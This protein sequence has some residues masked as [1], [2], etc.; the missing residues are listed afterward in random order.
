M[1]FKKFIGKRLHKN[2]K[3]CANLFKSVLKRHQIS[4]TNMEKPKESSRN[5]NR[6]VLLKKLSEKD[7]EVNN[8]HDRLDSQDQII[9]KLL[10]QLLS[11]N[12]ILTSENLTDLT[13]RNY[14]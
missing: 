5:G 8:L 4:D 10:D 3:L 11:I 12:S 6:T 2:K 9:Q 14:V 7:A 1:K 13:F